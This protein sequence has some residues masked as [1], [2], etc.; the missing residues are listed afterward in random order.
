MPAFSGDSLEP[1]Q[2]DLVDLEL[3]GH[4]R[5][6]DLGWKSQIS[7]EALGDVDEI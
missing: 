6:T 1:A 2:I 3:V 5:R 4:T 7:L